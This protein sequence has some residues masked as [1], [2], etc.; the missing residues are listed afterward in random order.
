[1]LV[2][3]GKSK[4][5]RIATLERQLKTIKGDLDKKLNRSRTKRDEMQ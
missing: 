5:D 2:E 3:T 1:M 4:D